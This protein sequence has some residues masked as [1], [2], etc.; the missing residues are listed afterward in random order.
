MKLLLFIMVASISANANQ[1]DFVTSYLEE[2]QAAAY[3]CRV[4]DHTGHISS[5]CAFR[6]GYEC[7][8]VY[9]CD[10]GRTYEE[11]NGNCGATYSDCW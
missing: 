8:D 1:N 4:V 9:Q 5:S 6:G 11:S 3:S 2:S 10:D 7:Y